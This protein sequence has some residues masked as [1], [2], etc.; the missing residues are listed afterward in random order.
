[1][2]VIPTLKAIGRLTILLLLTGVILLLTI[3]VEIAIDQLT[4]QTRDIRHL[5][6]HS[7]GNIGALMVLLSIAGYSIKKKVKAFPGKA[8]DWLVIHEW[9]SV[10]GVILIG[11]HTGNHFESMLP[12]LCFALTLVCLI[13]GFVGRHI[14]VKT[15]SDLNTRRAELL[16]SGLDKEEAD[17]ALALATA[18]TKALAQWRS[19][20]RP[21]SYS[22]GGLVCLHI[23]SAL[24]FGG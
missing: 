17:E 5:L 6:K 9:F 19:V 1:M 13:S 15:R 20:H 18:T 8:K 7:L 2:G 3:G 22:L 4:V 14:Y 12:A 11:V 24:F 16:K 23:V 21:M 10:V